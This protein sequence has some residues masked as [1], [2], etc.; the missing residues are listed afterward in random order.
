MSLDEIRDELRTFADDR[1][2]EQFHSPKN[3][4]MALAVEA[5]ELLELFQWLTQEES[6]AVATSQTDLARVKEEL[7]DIFI[8]L[9]RLADQ[10]GID[11]EQA[12][13]NKIGKNAEKYP[14]GKAHGS[15]AKYSDL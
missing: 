2:W 13:K 9:V 4:S 12:A 5:G 15:A 7:A 8:Y 6:R 1:D 14:V 11:L 10:L 3:L